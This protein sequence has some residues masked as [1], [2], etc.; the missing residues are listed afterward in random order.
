MEI[1]D[2]LMGF[3]LDIIFFDPLRQLY[4]TACTLI[5]NPGRCES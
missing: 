3:P 5:S 1:D 4:W 2:Q